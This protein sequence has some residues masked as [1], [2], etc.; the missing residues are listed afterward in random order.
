[1]TNY[2][3]NLIGDDGD[4]RIEVDPETARV[5]DADTLKDVEGASPA[6]VRLLGVDAPEAPTYDPS[7]PYQGFQEGIY[8]PEHTQQLETAIDSGYTFLDSQG[9]DVYGRDLADLQ[10]EQG[11]SF[12][13]DYLRE[14]LIG[15]SRYN[16]DDVNIDLAYAKGQ[17]D[18]FINDQV[19][20][21]EWRK[22][23]IITSR[24]QNQVPLGPMDLDNAGVFAPSDRQFSSSGSFDVL[25]SI[26]YWWMSN[27]TAYQGLASLFDQDGAKR[28]IEDVNE[29]FTGRIDPSLVVSLEQIDSGGD[30]LAWLGNNLIIQG[31]DFAIIAGSG[32]A[33]AKVGATVG[34]AF[35]GVGAVPGAA[36]GGFVGTAFGLGYT[37]LKSVGTHSA[38]QIETT[39]DV[40][41]GK[42]LAVGS[43]IALLDRFG[44]RGALKPTDFLEEGGVDKLVKFVAKKEGISEEAARAAVDKESIGL[45]RKFYDEIEF[46]TSDFVSKKTLALRIARETAKR[47]ALEGG[48]ELSQETLQYLSIHGVPQTAAEWKAMGIRLADAAAAGAAIGTVYQAPQSLRDRAEINDFRNGTTPWDYST[49]NVYE[50]RAYDSRKIWGDKTIEEGI[51]EYEGD[52]AGETIEERAAK[53]PNNYVTRAFNKIK[54]GQY[55]VGGSS[56]SNAFSRETLYNS[57]GQP[58]K[59]SFLLANIEGAQQNLPGHTLFNAEEQ[60]VARIARL[61]PWLEDTQKFLGIDNAKA[62]SLL[63]KLRANGLKLDQT[64]DA[65]DHDAARQIIASLHNVANQVNDWRKFDIEDDT[66]SVYKDPSYLLEA[67]LPNVKKLRNGYQESINKLAGAKLNSWYQGKKPGETVGVELATQIINDILEFKS[68]PELVRTLHQ[69]NAYETMPEFYAEDAVERLADKIVHETRSATQTQF[70]GRNLEVYSN[71]LNEMEREGVDSDIINGLAADLMDQVA[72]HNKTFGRLKNDKLAHAQDYIRT[73]TTLG[74]MDMSLF[75]QGGEAVMASIGTNKGLVKQLGEI[76]HSAVQSNAYHF[77]KLES[78]AI[79]EYREYGYHADEIQRQHGVGFDSIINQKINEWAFKAFQ[80]TAVTDA[81]RMSR[82]VPGAKVITNLATS[83]IDKDLNNLSKKDQQTLERLQFYGGNPKKLIGIMKEYSTLSPEAIAQDL[84]TDGATLVPLEYVEDL[85]DQLDAMVPK[86]IDEMTVRA[87][88]GSRPSWFE[89]KR[90]GLPFLTQYLSFT[91]HWSANQLPRMYKVYTRGGGTVAYSAFATIAGAILVAYYAQFLKDWLIYGEESPYLK[92]K[93]GAIERALLYSG[94]F[95][96]GGEA[97]DRFVSGPYGFGAAHQALTTPGK[98]LIGELIGGAIESP[99]ISHGEKIGEQIA[100]GEYKKAYERAAPWG[101]GQT[102]LYDLLRGDE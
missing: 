96:W 18:M 47:G 57:K 40:D 36:I 46:A 88:P 85:H 16:V 19:N 66:F 70:R 43:A 37:W 72:K 44:A 56:I 99:A 9:Q 4:N 82:M 58:I 25:E 91:A 81:I 8:S 61:S 28:R 30:A 48:T 101:H 39:G 73:A 78:D 32:A 33:G 23:E 35:G 38:E 89:D 92:D 65:K 87:K 12:A 10:T 68:S 27:K 59:G 17:M 5:Y 15:P 52:V 63:A 29:E 62:N 21:P 22:A 34:A 80:V 55:K 51:E 76:A 45:V 41:V 14:G 6:G 64:I 53:A 67:D 42:S 102:Y 74:I 2:L 86:F 31:P 71:I 50:Q 11:Y 7:R 24:I 93:T 79:Q 3:S 94:L 95:G 100:Q 84:A 75:A 20:L 83:L 90:F 54:R 49:A 69:M 13:Q 26:E 97:Y 98:S 1:M 60:R 77:A